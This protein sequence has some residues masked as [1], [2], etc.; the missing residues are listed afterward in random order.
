MASRVCRGSSHGGSYHALRDGTAASV[1]VLIESTDGV[2]LWRT[3]GSS[4]DVIEASWR[5][6]PDSLA[7]RLYMRGEGVLNTR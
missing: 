6:L 1:R 3:V 5:T 4:T 2:H 7:H